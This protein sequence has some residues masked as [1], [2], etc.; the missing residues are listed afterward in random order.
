M[1]SQEFRG[2]GQELFIPRSCNMSLFL[3][4]A[5]VSQQSR[6]T[7]DP[8]ASSVCIV[9]LFAFYLGVGARLPLARP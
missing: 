5:R 2:E 9:M 6:S 1:E 3:E 8:I 7:L 4:L